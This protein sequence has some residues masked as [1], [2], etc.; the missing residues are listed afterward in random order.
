MGEALCEGLRSFEEDA[1]VLF[2]HNPVCL[3]CRGGVDCQGLVDWN[4]AEGAHCWGQKP[5]KLELVCTDPMAVIV[6]S[7]DCAMKLQWSLWCCHGI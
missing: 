3:L 4:V 7:L 2:V 5:A 1:P 6:V